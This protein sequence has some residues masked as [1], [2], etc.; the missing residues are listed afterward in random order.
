MY[1]VDNTKCIKYM[2]KVLV[3]FESSF[4]LLDFLLDEI[5]EIVHFLII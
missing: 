4:E 1:N 3:I 2:E 5:I